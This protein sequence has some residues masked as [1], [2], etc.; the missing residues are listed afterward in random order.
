MSTD[1]LAFLEKLNTFVE[2]HRRVLS[3]FERSLAN[4][5]HFLNIARHSV[6]Q[7]PENT[8]SMLTQ[9]RE[10]G[11]LQHLNKQYEEFEQMA[12]T[13]HGMEFNQ[14]KLAGSLDTLRDHYDEILAEAEEQ[15][16]VIDLMLSSLKN[17]H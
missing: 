9:I 5:R 6:E 16:D 7:E 1:S 11:L 4:A 2:F 15:L 12:A 8:V 3:D 13:L 10:I 14:D 17:L